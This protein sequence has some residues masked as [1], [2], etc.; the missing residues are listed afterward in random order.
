MN[1]QI[2]NAY[3]AGFK[4]IE[5]A[6]I[7]KQFVYPSPEFSAYCKGKSTKEDAQRLAEKK[8]I[9][10]Y[11]NFHGYSDSDPYEVVKTISAKTVE[12][13]AMDATLDPNYKQEVI[14]G[15]FCG[16]TVNN[17]GDWIIKSNEKNP[18]MR[19]RWSEANQQWQKGKHMR[20]SMADAPYKFYDYNF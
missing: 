2:E 5:G 13:R 18:T 6:I 1:T 16:H 19:V 20:F 14:I 8:S 12:V 15:G 10:K 9:K 11:C 17:G 7:P 3:Q 4:S